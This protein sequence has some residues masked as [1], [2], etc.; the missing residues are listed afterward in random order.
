MELKATIAAEAEKASA[1]SRRPRMQG[2]TQPKAMPL[3]EEEM[4]KQA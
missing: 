3:Q 2:S 1:K 4:R